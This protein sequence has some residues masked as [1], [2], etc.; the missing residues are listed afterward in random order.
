MTAQFNSATSAA[1]SSI[2]KHEDGSSIPMGEPA[3]LVNRKLKLS[4]L[5]RK[6]KE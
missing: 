2:V 1:V 6:V 5:S 3:T 4:F